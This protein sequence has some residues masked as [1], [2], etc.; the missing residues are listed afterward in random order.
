M[1][2]VVGEGSSRLGT[3]S[4]GLSP[5]SLFDMLLVT[6]GGFENLMFPL[7]FVLLF[8]SFCLL[9]CGSFHFVHCIPLF[10]LGVLCFFMIGRVSS[11]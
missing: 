5:L 8:G 11:P 6:G 2:V 3:L 1:L 10:F 7:C 4:G 9:V